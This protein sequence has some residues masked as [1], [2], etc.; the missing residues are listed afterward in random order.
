MGGMLHPFVE[1]QA[2]PILHPINDERL[3]W[4]RWLRLIVELLGS[5]LSELL[6]LFLFLRVIAAF[7]G[8]VRRLVIGLASF[9]IFVALLKLIYCFLKGFHLS[10]ESQNLV[11]S[12]D[13]L[14]GCLS[15]HQLYVIHFVLCLIQ[16]LFHGVARGI[17][18]VVILLI[19]NVSDKLFVRMVESGFLHMGLAWSKDCPKAFKSLSS[20]LDE[21]KLCHVMSDLSHNVQGL[22][23]FP[24]DE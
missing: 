16:Q 9:L 21:D 1:S 8:R 6:I 12:R 17:L 22:A 15:F 13:S 2:P 18:S 3:F 5:F 24:N 7:G 20:P 23:K 19:L 14:C 10:S 11:L 4:I